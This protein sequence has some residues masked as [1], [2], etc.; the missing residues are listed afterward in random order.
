MNEKA[1]KRWNAVFH[2]CFLIV[3]AVLDA[4]SYHVFIFKNDFAPAGI[5]GIATMIQY[6]FSWNVGYLSLIVNIPLAIITFIWV[7]KKYAIRTMVFVI[8]FSVSCIVFEKLNVYQYDAGNNK[9]LASVAAGV[10]GGIIYG[11][12]LKLNASTGGM[13]YVAII[14]NHKFKHLSI[15]WIGFAINCVV[16]GASFFVYGYDMEAVI[17]C[18]IYCYTSSIFGDKI[19]KGFESAIKVEVITDK[20]DE[21]KEELLEKIKHGITQIEAKGVYSG[22]NKTLFVCIINKRELPNF[23]K[24]ISKYDNTFTYVS[25]INEIYGRFH[26]PRIL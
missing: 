11:Y 13:D 19:I 15:V 22:T 1:K 21:I 8:V 5:N 23:K 18:L 16:A 14:I 7:N 12:A 20:P 6:I 25:S 26:R 24:I 4:L 2:Y 10:I 3:L 17:L 9:L